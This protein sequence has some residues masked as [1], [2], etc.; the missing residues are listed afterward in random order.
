MCRP[1][2]SAPRPT[3]RF[4]SGLG[5]AVLAILGIAA[6][7][8]PTA[9]QSYVG[10]QVIG[11][12][13]DSPASGTNVGAGLRAGWDGLFDTE[14]V[15]G[16]VS[17]NF[18]PQEIRAPE[19]ISRA[20]YFDLFIALTVHPAAGPYAGL[21]WGW[22]LSTREGGQVGPGNATA[23]PVLVGFRTSRFVIEA[24]YWGSLPEVGLDD[25]GSSRRLA[26]TLALIGG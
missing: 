20:S 6:E 10:L 18:I 15:S 17:A 13:F 12:H 2:R 24:E 8:A 19:E 22:L 5:A 3:H 23:L 11:D 4:R 14:V 7:P 1:F 26:V 9:A 16:L 25:E 21:G